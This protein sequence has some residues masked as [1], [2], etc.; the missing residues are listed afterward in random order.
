VTVDY[1][2]ENQTATTF[3]NPGGPDYATA[4]GSLT[5]APGETQKTF[6]VT[7]N[8]DMVNETNETFLV[9]LTNPSSNAAIQD[10]TGV[11]TIVN[12]DA[13]PSLAIFDTSVTEGD[14][15]AKTM[16]FMVELS[17]ISGQT[18]TVSYA[19]SN[20]TA[21]TN[22]LSVSGGND[23]EAASGI[24]SFSPGGTVLYI[25]ITVNGDTTCEPNEQINVT[26]SA[27]V[28]A[29]LTD[30]SAVGTIMNDD[31]V[32]TISVADQSV[33]EGSPAIGGS[34]ITNFPFI[35]SLSNPRSVAVTVDYATLNNT[36][37]AG[38][39]FTAASGS[40]T[41]LP[42]ETTRLANVAVKKDTTVEPNETFF[43]NLMNPT[44]ATLLDA[45]AVG[46]IVN[47]DLP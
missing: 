12:D 45:Q 47:D 31:A 44:Q 2:T 17:A 27:P 46:T 26:L 33:A 20:V 35:V 11:G 13:V 10:G 5:F 9:H 23:Y 7:V 34:T 30:A 22:G 8:G 18:V 4:S 25:H 32:P 38:S 6:N 15:G 40:V 41:F 21:S 43:L 1:A 37:F 16:T 14:S 3:V 24:L 42:G 28:N 36:A 19:T 39:D 29:T